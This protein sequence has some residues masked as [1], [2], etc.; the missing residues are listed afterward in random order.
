MINNQNPNYLKHKEEKVDYEYIIAMGISTG[1]PKL[2]NQ[3]LPK[4]EAELSAAYVIV[5]HMPPGFTKPLADRL[6]NVSSLQVKEAENG[7]TL[8]RGVVYI[9]PGGKQFQITKQAAPQVLLTDEEPYKGHRPSVNVML[10]SLAKLDLDKKRIIVIIMTGMGTDGLEGVTNLKEATNCIVV[11][12][13]KDSSTVYGMPK[14]VAS[15]GLA[16]YV[17]PAEEINQIIKKI[18]GGNYGR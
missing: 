6:N 13:D 10:N 17:V 16:D 9:A 14:A 15:A 1:G 7:E 12:Q 11:A 18:A 2:L 5:Q 8:K 3:L 4:L